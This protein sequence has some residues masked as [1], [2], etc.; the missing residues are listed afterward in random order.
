[1]AISPAAVGNLRSGDRGTLLAKIE[2]HLRAV[3]FL[4]IALIR[5]AKLILKDL[6]LPN[7]DRVYEQLLRDGSLRL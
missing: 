1:M 7:R 6:P 2:R 3:L 4:P 5:F